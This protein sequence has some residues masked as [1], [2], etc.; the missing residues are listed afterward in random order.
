M[1]ASKDGFDAS[2]YPRLLPPCKSYQ[3]AK[4]RL[5]FRPETLALHR[6]WMFLVSVEDEEK[7]VQLQVLFVSDHDRAWCEERF[8]PLDPS[9]FSALYWSQT[10]RCWMMLEKTSTRFTASGTRKPL[11]VNIAIA[12]NIQWRYGDQ[13][14]FARELRRTP[15]AQVMLIA[16]HKAIGHAYCPC[17]RGGLSLCR[18]WFHDDIPGEWM[19]E[20][21]EDTYVHRCLREADDD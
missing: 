18:G 21:Y 14:S 17:L 7:T 20:D 8:V 3:E 13:V 9:G 15:R 10:R 16:P 11:K 6:A 1:Q 5:L 4:R 12:A 2:A 19:L